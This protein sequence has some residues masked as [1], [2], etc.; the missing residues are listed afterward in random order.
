[1]LVGGQIDTQAA[2]EP[3]GPTESKAKSSRTAAQIRGEITERF[4][5][6][7]TCVMSWGHG[8]IPELVRGPGPPAAARFPFIAIVLST[9]LEAYSPKALKAVNMAA[10][11]RF[12]L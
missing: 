9:W 3:W 12:G 7:S 2:S 1:M 10:T 8:Q 4:A 11:L 5:M 6:R